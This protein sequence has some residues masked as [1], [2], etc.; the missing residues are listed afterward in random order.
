MSGQRSMGRTKGYGEVVMSEKVSNGATVGAKCEQHTGAKK[1]MKLHRGIAVAGAQGASLN[2]G[3]ADLVVDCAGLTRKAFNSGGASVLSGT[4]WLVEA[5]TPTLKH[6]DTVFIE[7]PD[8]GIP[9]VGV[10]FWRKLFAITPDGARVVFACMGGHGRTGTA[11]ACYVAAGME[12]ELGSAGVAD[13]A[14]LIRLVR[15]Q[16]CGCAVESDQQEDYIARVVAQMRAPQDRGE[17]DRQYELIDKARGERS[18][19]RA[20]AKG[21]GAQ[22]SLNVALQTAQPA[23]PVAGEVTSLKQAEELDGEPQAE[24]APQ[25]TD[26][27]EAFL[28][29]ISALVGDKALAACVFRDAAGSLVNAGGALLLKRSEMTSK[30]YAWFKHELKSWGQMLEEK[31]IQANGGEN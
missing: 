13:A 23:A 18:K 2:F 10:R 24:G 26:Q 6:P 30:T 14:D 8:M 21:G 15:A 25:R 31:A 27:V 12:A 7:W 28:R 19:L 29:S 5:L 1:A 3:E 20:F 9:S 16:H 17:L 11:M 22:K 4:A